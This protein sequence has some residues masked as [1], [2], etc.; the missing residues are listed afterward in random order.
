VH[1]HPIH[2]AIPLQQQ[3]AIGGPVHGPAFI[4]EVIEEIGQ[5]HSDSSKFPSAPEAAQG[6]FRREGEFWTIACC[7]EVFRLRDVRGLVYI[8]Y[9]CVA[10]C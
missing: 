2:L 10:N 6:V 5:P 1:F 8:A 3:R 9:L 7:G 4:L